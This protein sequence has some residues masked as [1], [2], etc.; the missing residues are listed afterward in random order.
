MKNNPAITSYLVQPIYF[1][2][3]KQEVIVG[4]FLSLN[5]REFIKSCQ[6]Q[7]LIVLYFLSL[8]MYAIQGIRIL[9]EYFSKFLFTFV[10]KNIFCAMVLSKF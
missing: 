8:C 4:L 10:H 6:N 7:N 1:W 9:C 2:W 3:T 5:K